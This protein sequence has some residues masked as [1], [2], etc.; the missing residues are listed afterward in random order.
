M[1]E[2]PPK[3]VNLSTTLNKVNSS[4][5]DPLKDMAQHNGV[6]EGKDVPKPTPT[7]PVTSNSEA[8]HSHQAQQQTPG[9]S[10]VSLPNQMSQGQQVPATAGSHH[11]ISEYYN[12]GSTPSYPQMGYGTLPYPSHQ[13][14]YTA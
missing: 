12:R 5:F 3:D 14:S 4:E 11:N 9:P 2:K 10:P 8:A 6:E 7:P 13:Y 1:E